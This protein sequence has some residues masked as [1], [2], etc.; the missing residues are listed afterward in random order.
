MTRVVRKWIPLFIATST[1]LVTLAGYLFPDTM[2]AGYRDRLVQWAVIVAAFALIYGASNVLRVHSERILRSEE[3]WSYSLALLVAASLFWIPP[4]LSGRSSAM[5]QATLDYFLT[6]LAASLAALLVLTLTLSAV[7]MLLYRRNLSSLLFI[8]IVALALLGTTPPLG[9]EWLS[10]IRDWL[11]R[12]PGMAG[13]RGLLLGVALGTVITG[14]RVLLGQD[15]P[16][17]ES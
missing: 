4:L 7:R 1:G 12:V 9:L 10:D 14:L 2:L 13:I 16:H 3:G 15:R 11:I 5:T 17:A 6:P 8:G